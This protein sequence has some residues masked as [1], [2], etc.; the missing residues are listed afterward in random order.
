MSESRLAGVAV[1]ISYVSS[2]IKREGVT[3]VPKTWYTHFKPSPISC[4]SLQGSKK[5]VYVY[6]YGMNKDKVDV[7]KSYLYLDSA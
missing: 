5:Y 1:Y 7:N 3:H 2:Y 4:K 6:G